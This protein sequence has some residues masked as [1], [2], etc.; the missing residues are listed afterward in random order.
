MIKKSIFSKLEIL[1]KHYKKIETDL[2][3]TYTDF[4]EKKFRV[5]SKEYSKLNNIFWYFREWS[6]YKED[7]YTAKNMLSNLELYE[8]AKEILT[9][10]INNKKKMEKKLYYLL[11][12]NVDKKKCGCFVEIRAASGGKEA[13]LFSGV[14]FRMYNRFSDVKKWKVEIISKT[15]G[16]YGG[17]KEIIIRIP[18]KESYD[19]LKFESGGHRVQRIPETESQ[20]RIHSSSCT[21]VVLPEVEKKAINKININD[22]RIDTFRSSGAGGQHVNTTD[23]AIRIIHFPT[24]IV[25]S[26]QDERSQ[27]KNKSKALSLLSS[28]LLYMKNTRIKQEES[29]KKRHLLGTGDRSDRIRTYN[30][31]K[32]RVTDHRVNL[33]LYCLEEILE[34]NLQNLITPIIQ[35]KQIEKFFR[36]FSI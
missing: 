35:E 19:Q 9:E 15:I 16:E 24:G 33:T 20:G 34:G 25:V 5:L 30:F 7:I 27:H 28:K 10:S 14:L 23:S 31:P 13:S 2:S 36:I 8:M 4:D 12:S 21:V 26:C 3:K 1:Q 29:L 6:R 17:Y 18:N 11:S 32:N 22:I